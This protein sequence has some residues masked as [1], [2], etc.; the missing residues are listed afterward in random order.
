M[1]DNPIIQFLTVLCFGFCA[2]VL[3][4]IWYLL[5]FIKSPILKFATAFSA[6]IKS[7]DVSLKQ[8]AKGITTVIDKSLEEV[9]RETE[10]EKDKIIHKQTP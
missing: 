5:R 8:L 1:I 9:E 3:F 10:N 2:G 7:S 6:K 4:T